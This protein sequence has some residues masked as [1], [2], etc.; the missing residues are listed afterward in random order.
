MRIMTILGSPRRQ[1]NTAKVLCWIEEELQAAGHTVDRVDV[2]DCN[3]R[4][5]G[6]CMA[7]KQGK[8]ELCSIQDDANALFRRMAA[9]DGI[10][11]AAPVFCWGFPA[12]LKA[13]VDRTFCM[14]DFDSPPPG[15]P[16]LIGK[17]MAL[18]LTA[19][20]EEKDNTDLVVRG[21]EQLVQYLNASLFHPL[22]VTGCSTP[23][24]LGDDVKAQAVDFAAAFVRAE[25]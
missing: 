12:Q 24:A 22:L 20:G 14:M 18:L 1:G 2:V 5:C 25:G 13:L 17:R 7:C 15:S 19:G 8:I 3:V 6:E 10:L 16:R 21:F 4:G 11:F 23:K 9:S